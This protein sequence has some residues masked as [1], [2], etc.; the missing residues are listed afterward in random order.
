MKAVQALFKQHGSGHEWLKTFS[1]DAYLHSHS[2]SMRL[3]DY[4][5]VLSFSAL[6]GLD[7]QRVQ[8]QH[9]TGHRKLIAHL[10]CEDCSKQ[11][12]SRPAKTEVEHMDTLLALL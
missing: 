1:E 6:G 11:T 8:C 3:S 2:A 10:A 5:I 4:N 7:E 9:H 12:Q